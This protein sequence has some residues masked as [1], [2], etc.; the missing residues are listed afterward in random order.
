MRVAWIGPYD[1]MSVAHR[2]D[3]DFTSTFHPATWIRNAALA[4]AERADVEL[5]ILMHDKRF[6]RDY[7]FQ[8][9]GLHFHFFHAPVPQIPRPVALYQLDRWKFY[10]ELKDIQP[11][12]VHGHGTENLF[13]YVAV[14]SG[15]P[16]VI[17]IQAIISS[18]L[19]Q[20]RRVSRRALEHVIVRFIERYT[21]KRAE[22]FI[23]KAPFAEEFVRSLNPT[24]PV[25]LLENI[26]HE[27]FFE[28]ERRPS[29]K[30]RKII[31]IGTLIN[32]K[33]VEELIRSFGAIA[34]HHPDVE[35]HLVGT[36]TEAYVEGVVKPLMRQSRGTIVLRGH[37]PSAQIAQEFAEA[38]MVV[39][40]SYFETS[41]NVI[42]EAM[43][44]GVPVIGTDVGG[45]PFMITHDKTGQI[46]PVRDVLRLTEAI[47]RYLDQP[48][49]AQAHAAAGRAEA[50]KRYSRQRYVDSLL[51]IYENILKHNAQHT[52]GER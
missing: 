31:F 24:A 48:S 17:S 50:R 39:L 49:L 34:P 22:N 25:F 19:A 38:T 16:H 12:L 52:R 9:Q 37:V 29:A 5:H 7:R 43:V 36:G 47:A 15:Y 6:K 23:I 42:A 26:V 28:V 51:G 35:L 40:P 45:I 33:G 41:P 44:A 2:M 46:V 8:E 4:V 3:Q 1:V 32:T 11:D 18:L 21:V 27:V 20:Y 14:T 13:S 10:K 30:G